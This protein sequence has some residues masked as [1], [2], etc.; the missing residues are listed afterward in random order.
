[1]GALESRDWGAEEGGGKAARS[2]D[3]LHPW[4]V[5]RPCV[6]SLGRGQKGQR[7]G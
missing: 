7:L 2:G 4:H 1:V 5:W 6:G 3:A